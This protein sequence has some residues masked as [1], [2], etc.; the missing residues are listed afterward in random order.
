MYC[1]YLRKSRADQD[2]E[3]RGEGETLARHEK[4]LL[5]LS[6]KLKL[7]ITGIYREIVSGETIS[8]RPVVQKL[9]T[10][11]Q[12]GKWEGVLV[13]EIERLARGNTLDQGI[14]SQAFQIGSTKIVTPMK[15]Y[16]PNNEF[17]EEYFE[18]G[19]FMS[20]REYK[21]I[22]RRIQRGRIAS[23]NEGKFLSSSPPF[24]YVR[25][26]IKN[27]KGY[28]LEPH[29]EQA[30]ILKMIYDMYVNRRLGSNLISKEL[31]RMS[32]KTSNG[33]MFGSSSVREI[34]KNPTYVGKIQWGHRKKTKISV[35]G[36][37][38]TT[39]KIDDNCL[40]VKG[41]HEP[42]ISQELFDDAQ[43]IR[44][45]RIIPSM[46]SASK[47]L[48]NPFAGI[49]VCGICG[50][51]MV[52]NTMKKE[53]RKEKHRIR[54]NNIEC[55][56]KTSCFVYVEEAILNAMNEWLTLQKVQLEPQESNAEQDIKESSIS[57][58][59]KEK[60]VINSQISKLHD[61][62]EQGVYT[63]EM[64]LN[65]SKTLS[66]K[67]DV[68]NDNLKLANIEFEKSKNAISAEKLV[69]K[70]TNI[71]EEY[72]SIERNEDK[73][74]L[75]KSVI[76]KITYYKSDSSYGNARAFTLELFPLLDS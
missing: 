69:I 54:C 26:K 75:L 22:N 44:T 35:G 62:L 40:L 72:D 48:K 5:D 29:P 27:D 38:K 12:D 64:F 17:D 59:I 20:R 57:L 21:T 73:N 31:N 39:R 19:L 63:S 65:R 36:V 67:L 37:I 76:S 32:V 42:L 66:D 43:K 11:V 25:V 52:L 49:L 28:T 7:N 58:L 10:E 30:A 60:E 2:A 3:L 33:K 23:V 74:T 50:R 14:V 47:S 56:N 68:I 1:M 41:L 71:I 45:G 55:E 46:N 51:N 34:L 70:M 9:L 16:D 4:M 15:T 8:S 53:T 61:L 6:K 18:F 24:G 13:V